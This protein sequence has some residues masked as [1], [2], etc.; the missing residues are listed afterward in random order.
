M[1]IEKIS[2]IPGI[3]SKVAERLIK[4][5]GSEEE[6]IK[7]IMEADIAKLMSVPGIGQGLA[8]RIVRNAYSIIEGVS[9]EEVLKTSDA[10]RM[11]ERIL[12]IIRGYTKTSYSKNKL[13][14]YFPLPPRKI[15]VMLERLN[16][17]SEAKELAEK[18]DEKTSNEII[19][20]LSKI[21]PLRP[22]KLEKRIG[23][24]VILTDDEEIYNKLCE[25]E[26]DKL[27]NIFLVKPGERLEEYIQS[28]DLVLF[29]SSGVPYDTSIDYAFN[30]EVLGKDVSV[31]F[32]LPEITISF[33]SLNY[34]VIKAACELGKHIHSLPGKS[35]IEKFKNRID[36]TALNEVENLLSALT[37]DGEVKEGYDEELDR[38]RTAIQSLQAIINDLEVQIND[39]VKRKIAEKKVVIEG[40]R[41]LDIL[42]EAVTS[43]AGGE[44]LRSVLP[45]LSGELLEIITEVSQKAEDNLCKM[46]KLT[47]EELE[48]VEELFPRD[49][50]LPIQADRRK[51]SLL[52]DFLRKEYALRRYKI[53]REIASKLHELRSAVEEAVKAL[54][55]FDLFFAVG[56][57]AKD[58]FLNVPTLSI[59][60]VGIG[61]ANGRNLFLRELELKS[62]IK[63]IPVSYTVGDTP[64]QSPNTNK[65]RIVVLSGANSGGKTT[66]LNL[67][68]QIV[69]LAQMGLPVPAEEVHMCPFDEIYLFS[70]SRGIMDA[71]A[72]EATLKNFA[73]V[74]TSPKK[75]LVLVDELEAITEPGAAA[76]VIA[77][78]LELLYAN[79]NTCAI[80]ISHLAEEVMKV[81][82]VL[83]RVDGIEASGLDENL[84]LIVDRNPIYNYLARSTPELIVERLYH[85]SK[86]S[87]REV[88]EKLLEEFG[89]RK[90]R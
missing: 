49:L 67:I 61:F 35:A 47:G 89:G 74:I 78:I 5:L 31:E 90:S 27:T 1:K 80:F 14:L 8:T 10:R 55:D 48:F 64:I 33:C 57:F 40:E 25:L 75:K 12:D 44:S 24:R 45:E 59:E 60:Y 23:D 22:E 65:E 21:R 11:Y 34:E 26:L 38:L 77:G 32:L 7:A 16:Y 72:F 70:R 50:A 53:V 85:L 87:E 15:N 86:G 28:Y 30:A 84:N 13:T 56:R 41:L 46:L 17:F 3:G 36:L 58:Y 52:E 63:V 2:Q 37:E 29:I 69:I 39:E 76:K 66:L 4:Y 54:L 71:G 68:A 9:L 51:V 83:I 62:K 88:Y 73:K 6:I 79:T 82:K 20:G 19:E 43:G 81:V 18:L 42:K